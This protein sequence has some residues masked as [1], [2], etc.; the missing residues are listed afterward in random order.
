MQPNGAGVVG[1]GRGQLG[2]ALGGAALVIAVVALVVGLTHAGPTGPAGAPATALWATVSQTRTPSCTDIASSGVTH[3]G[4]NST[5]GY[6]VVTFDQNTTNCAPVVTY[7][8]HSAAA[9]VVSTVS[10][11]GL[12]PSSVGVVTETWSGSSWV[13]DYPT[14]SLAVFC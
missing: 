2:T 3:V 7:A 9:D 4:W 10:P 13:A 12:S 5:L 14:F 1:P 11:A 6:C 8:A